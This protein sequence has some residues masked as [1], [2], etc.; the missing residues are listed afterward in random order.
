MVSAQITDKDAGGLTQSNLIRA[1]AF[2]EPK[3]LTPAGGTGLQLIAVDGKVDSPSE[4]VYGLIPISQVRV[5][6]EGTHHVYVRGQDA[7]GNWGPMFGVNLVVDKTAPVLG[8]L[9]GTPDPTNGAA[10]VD[11]AAP[12][13]EAVGLG[14]AEFWLGTAD[15]GVGKATRA[16]V[17]V[18][19]SNAAVSVPLAGIALGAQRFNLRVQD[20][21]GNWSTAVNTTVTVS[22]PNLVYGNNFEPADPAW[23]ASTGAVSTT[24]AAAMATAAETGSTR[25]LQVTMAG[26]KN[27]QASYLTDN[28]PSVESSYHARFVFNRSTLAPGNGNTLTLFE[29]R[30]A[31]NGSLFTVQYR[32]NGTTPQLRTSMS[33]S[34]GGPLTGNWTNLPAGNVTVQLDWVTG[35]AT[36]PTAG[37]LVLKMNGTSVSTQTGN[38]G[39]LRLET[40]LLGVTAGFSTTNAGTTIGTA[41]FDS[42]LS[43][44]FTLP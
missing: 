29:G 4:T 28:T 19:N 13:T 36:G 42:F 12:V 26:K 40:V 2:L 15:P 21:A 24:P 30:N 18:V 6:S 38:T 1:E 5:L 8:A 25:G 7:A 17:S 16:S 32:I 22:K 33:R 27:N 23:N 31:Q 35:P 3:N 10:N 43:T 34:T 44:R 39:T 14:A 37:S 41:Y 9:S 11:L 20:T